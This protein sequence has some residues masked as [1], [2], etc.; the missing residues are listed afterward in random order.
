MPTKADY[1]SCIEL[2]FHLLDATQKKPFVDG[3]KFFKNKINRHR[4]D[5]L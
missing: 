3:R 4:V 2:N 1:H 5:I